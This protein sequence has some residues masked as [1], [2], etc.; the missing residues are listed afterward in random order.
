MAFLITK[1]LIFGFQ[2]LEL[3]VHF[4]ASLRYFTKFVSVMTFSCYSYEV[5]LKTVDLILGKSCPFFL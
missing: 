2:I 3:K 5:I 1:K 4:S